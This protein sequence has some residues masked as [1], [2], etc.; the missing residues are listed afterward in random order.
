MVSSDGSGK[1][2]A[3][4]LKRKQQGKKKTVIKNPER[5]KE[6]RE[7][8]VEEEEGGGNG[9][10]KEN[11]EERVRRLERTVALLQQVILDD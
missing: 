9:Q 7:R 2:L 1:L 8:V 11:L 3:E 6:L 10:G 4:A 5:V